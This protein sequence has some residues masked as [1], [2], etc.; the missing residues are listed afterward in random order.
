MD[1]AN[2]PSDSSEGGSSATAS[3]DD[4]GSRNDKSDLKTQIYQCL[5]SISEN[6]SGSFAT[7]GTLST[8]ENP[9]LS[10]H[11][12][13]TI[14][15]PLSVRDAI[16]LRKQCHQAPFGK[17]SDTIVDKGVRNTWELSSDQFELRNPA[18]QATLRQATQQVANALGIVNGNS[19]MRAELYK[20]LL[21]DEGAFFE[22]HTECVFT[23]SFLRIELTVA[24]A[25]RKPPACSV[26]W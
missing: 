26:L 15:L 25:L 5:K 2:D 14:G 10:V 24:A 3:T 4:H 20:L 12:L 21:Y 19:S 16:E 1:F 8:S 23:T 9:G 7:A 22:N 11:G 13:G 17:G 18:W 6:G